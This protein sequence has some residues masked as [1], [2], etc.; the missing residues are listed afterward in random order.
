MRKAHVN[1]TLTLH[2]GDKGQTG[3]VDVG[4]QQRE[5]ARQVGVGR[6]A[7]R[8][9]PVVV[10]VHGDILGGQHVHERGAR[11]AKQPAA[12]RRAGQ[13]QRNGVVLRVERVRQDLHAHTRQ[14]SRAPPPPDTHAYTRMTNKPQHA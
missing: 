11:R 8:R 14:A 12:G 5:H 9:H 3:A 1:E 2:S 6:K 10:V 7:G 13:V 4:G